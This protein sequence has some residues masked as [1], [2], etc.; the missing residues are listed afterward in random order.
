MFP[1]QG[2]H[3]AQGG[4]R[5]PGKTAGTLPVTDVEGIQQRGE[6]AAESHGRAFAQG[7]RMHAGL[8]ALPVHAQQGI[9]AHTDGQGG[10]RAHQRP[11]AAHAHAVAVHHRRALGEQG[12]VRG[13]AAHVQQH[14]TGILR[15]GGAQGQD[16]HDAGR[17][18]GQHRLHG[19]LPG[20]GRR[21]GAAVGLEQAQGGPDARLP[22]ALLHGGQKAVHDAGHGGIVIGRGDA[23]REIELAGQAVPA[24]RHEPGGTHHL[25]HAQLVRG[26]AGRKLAHAG[27]GPHA[28]LFPGGAGVGQ[29]TGIQRRHLH[30]AMVQTAGQDADVVPDGEAG[31]RQSRSGAQG[32]GHAIGPALHQGVDGQGGAHG[33]TLHAAQARRALGA[34]SFFQSLFQSGQCRAYGKG[35]VFVTGGRLG[36]GQ[37]A[38]RPAKHGIGVRAA[39]IDPQK[40]LRCHAAST[41]IAA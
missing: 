37:D 15:H 39:R 32:Q 31:G 24:D 36:P 6:R 4:R 30:A 25:G 41:G 27:H 12:H 16:A 7:A 17:R 13:G 8:R 2:R 23:A 21:D 14:G 29:G 1:G 5:I 28:L 33:H 35:Q 9:P 34:E 22:Q 18:A 38:F 19:F 26:V 40:R 3:R 20:Q 10:Q 11:A